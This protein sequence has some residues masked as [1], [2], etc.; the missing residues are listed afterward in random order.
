LVEGEKQTID[1]NVFEGL[2]KY[3]KPKAVIF[4]PK[5]KQTENGK[6]LRKETSQSIL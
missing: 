3:E 5:F 6:I 4:V 2:D 1:E